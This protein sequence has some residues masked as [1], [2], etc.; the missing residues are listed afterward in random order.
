M[1]MVMVMA[2]LELD[3]GVMA[4]L[5]LALFW[6]HVVLI[7]AAALA[8]L[9]ALARLG[10]GVR[11]GWSAEVCSARGPEGMLARNR[12]EQLGRLGRR[13]GPRQIYFHDRSHHSEVF[14]GT[15]RLD[16]GR[17]V[18][19]APA[20]GAQAEVWPELAS[21]SE[22]ASR[23]EPAGF[24][25]AALAASR[26]RGFERAVE[27]RIGVGDRVFVVGRIVEGRVVAD[28]TLI[29]ATADPRAWLTRARWLAIGFVLL[30]L[31]LAGLCTALAVWPPYFG[32]VSTLGA[33]GALGWFLAVQPLGV[34]VHDALRTPDRAFLRGSWREG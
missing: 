10:R 18:E 19:L 7:A 31:A 17:E 16:D 12:V 27:T 22:R 2:A 24:D 6:I 33:A 5:A 26:A 4:A 21:R 34:A 20:P 29:L 23:V 32:L 28:A 14:G 25:E 9:R 8:D 13:G 30:D 1:A 11:E 15:L 3:G